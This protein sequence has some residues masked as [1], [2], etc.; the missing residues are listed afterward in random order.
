MRK[1][2]RVGLNNNKS[3]K[4]LLMSLTSLPFQA[5]V[6]L[7]TPQ[8]PSGDPTLVSFRLLLSHPLGL[9]YMRVDAY[10]KTSQPYKVE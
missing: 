9:I 2:L 5:T 4:I 10:F 1:E 8:Y 7:H 3:K 6:N